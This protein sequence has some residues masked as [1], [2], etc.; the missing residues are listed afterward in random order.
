MITQAPPNTTNYQVSGNYFYLGRETGF[1]GVFDVD[2][3]GGITGSIQDKNSFPRQEVK[4][5][6][7]SLDDGVEME[8]VKRAVGPAYADIHYRLVGGKTLHSVEGGYDGHFHFKPIADDV[9]G[10]SDEGEV[11]VAGGG[12]AHLTLALNTE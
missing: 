6:L 3:Q 12:L 11:R 2:G 10:L 9:L 4:G 7:R 5:N 1:T 8:F